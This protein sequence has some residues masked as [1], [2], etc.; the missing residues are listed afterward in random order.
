M[1]NNTTESIYAVLGS[2]PERAV[3]F[4]N[5]MVVY[6]KKPEQDPA[7]L[8][9]FF[10]WASLGQARVVHVGGGPGPIAMALAKRHGNLHVV[11]QDMAFMLGA[12]DAGVPEELKGRVTIVPHDSFFASQTVAADVFLFRWSLRNWADKHCIMALRAQ[13][14]MLK[15]GGRVIIQDII[16]PEPGAGPLWRERSA[17]SND[18]SLAAS[19]NS[20]DRSAAEW[21]A[22]LQEADSRFVLKSVAEPKGSALGILEVVWEA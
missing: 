2:N 10:D 6:S 3:Q 8:T 9:D 12:G 11:A 22:L 19:F 14:P 16:L 20:R 4:G 1:A 17:R 13:I 15:S 18:L 7:F 5:A 21:K